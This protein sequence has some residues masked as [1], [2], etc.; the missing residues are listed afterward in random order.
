MRASGSDIIYAQ[1]ILHLEPTG[2]NDELTQAAVRNFQLKNNIPVSGELD[3][4]TRESMFDDELELTTDLSDRYG[5]FIQ[6]YYLPKGEYV[7]YPILCMAS[8]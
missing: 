3:M 1:R 6:N 4:I 5:N 7:E 8:R 2:I